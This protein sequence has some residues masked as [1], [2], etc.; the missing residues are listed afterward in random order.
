[1]RWHAAVIGL[2]LVVTLGL[3][4]CSEQISGTPQADP[5]ATVKLDTG[6]YPTT[7]RD[8]GQRT[9]FDAGVQGS[10]A[11]AG[12]LVAP[13]EVDEKFDVGAYSPI[14]IMPDLPM[15]Q[16]V[17][18]KSLAA[19]LTGQVGGA[20]VAQKVDM[21]G[22]TAPAAQMNTMVLRYE[23]PEVAASGLARVRSGLPPASSAGAPLA[24]YK[25]AFEGGAPEKIGGSPH[26]WLQHKEY[27]VGVGFINVTSRAD[28][29]RL[30]TSFY[31]KQLPR[32]DALPFTATETRA[33]RQTD[34]DGI[35]RLTRLEEVLPNG[36]YYSTGWFTPHAWAIAAAERWK[37]MT[38]MM[39]RASIEVVANSANTV[40]RARD[41]EGASLYLRLSSVKTAAGDQDE[42]AAPG[43]PGVRCESG[44]T[45][46][47]GRERR[48]YACTFALGR[49]VVQNTGASLIAA[50]QGAAA[51]YLT[52][53]DA[54]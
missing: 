51:S 33:F 40:L 8:V 38:D 35:M 5:S 15:S 41:P 7:A 3:S 30:A 26:F 19:A 44:L 10:F 1:M 13:A 20:V 22:S 47:N 11:L 4:S 6:N 24:K 49:H 43:V 18:G 28:I 17:L 21:K 9:G 39:T 37:N 54:K 46:A 53:K 50:Q 42:D 36:G 16:I 12:Y 31:D 48:V 27:L 52:V 29:E 45:T 14:P 25:D 34:T 23:S 2:G 32:L